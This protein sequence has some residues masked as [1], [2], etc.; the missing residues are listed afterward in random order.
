M[1][2]TAKGSFQSGDESVSWLL[3]ESGVLKVKPSATERFMVKLRAGEDAGARARNEFE[4][5][6]KPA[7]APV[8]RAVIVQSGWAQSTIIQPCGSTIYTSGASAG[9]SSVTMELPAPLA[10]ESKARSTGYYYAAVPTSERVL[11]I[12]VPLRID[13]PGAAVSAADGAIRQDI[14]RK[15]ADNSY[16]YAHAR[17]K[18]YHV[19][20]VPKRIDADGKLTPW[21]PEVAPSASHSA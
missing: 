18:D 19:P 15:G 7:K 13:G 6:A 2:A 12:A 17:V 3:Y 9:P 20:V 11:P 1:P 21:S 5:R 10:P 8:A 16:Y 14:E 4:E